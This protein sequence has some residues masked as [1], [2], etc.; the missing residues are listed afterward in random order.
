MCCDSGGHFGG[1]WMCRVAGL[2]STKTE[3]NKNQYKKHT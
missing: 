3:I 1:Y 2:V